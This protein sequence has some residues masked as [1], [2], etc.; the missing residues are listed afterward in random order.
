MNVASRAPPMTRDWL[1]WPFFGESH[2]AFA[3]ALDRFV[4]S[5]ATGQRIKA[6][7]RSPSGECN[8]RRSLRPGMGLAGRGGIGRRSPGRRGNTDDSLQFGAARFGRIDRSIRGVTSRL[9]A[10]LYAC[11]H[12]LVN[13]YRIQLL[14]CRR[15]E[16]RWHVEAHS[17]SCRAVYRSSA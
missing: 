14:R 10:S 2:H 4:A 1:D 7:Q 11:D 12:Q 8:T 6:R 17:W 16:A 5:G 3:G 13:G 15:T 9:N